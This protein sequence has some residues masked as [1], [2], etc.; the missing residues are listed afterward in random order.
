MHVWWFHRHFSDVASCKI[1]RFPEP[2]A[3]Q[4]V[5][6]SQGE[7]LAFIHMRMRR[8]TFAAASHRTSHLPQI[9]FSDRSIVSKSPRAAPIKHECGRNTR[10]LDWVY[11][12]TSILQRSTIPSQNMNVVAWLIGLLLNEYTFFAASPTEN[13]ACPHGRYFRILRSC[14]GL[15]IAT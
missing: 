14:G 8:L 4:Q 13:Q 12:R 15:S 1:S 10:P 7:R 2:A 9:C 6:P 3:W 5:L 11:R